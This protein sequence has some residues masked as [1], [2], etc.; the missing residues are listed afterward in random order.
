MRIKQ[1]IIPRETNDIQELLISYGLF[2]ILLDMNYEFPVTLK[3]KKGAYIIDLEEEVETEDIIVIPTEKDTDIEKLNFNQMINQRSFNT[4][5]AKLYGSPDEFGDFIGGFLTSDD[6]TIDKIFSYY[7][8]L[9]DEHIKSFK[10]EKSTFV[11]GVYTGLGVRG[12]NSPVPEQMKTF[13]T[14]LSI[15]GY[16]RATSFTALSDNGNEFT[17][18]AIPSEKGIEYLNKWHPYTKIDKETGEIVLS[19]FL[20]STSETITSATLKVKLQLEISMSENLEDFYGFYEIQVAPTASTKPL[21]DKVKEVTWLQFSENLLVE[22]NKLLNYSTTNIDV[23]NSVASF[24]TLLT[25][26]SYT[27]M[28]QIIAKKSS[29]P[30]F[31]LGEAKEIAKMVNKENLLELKAIKDYAYMLNQFMYKDKGIGYQVQRELLSVNNQSKLMSALTSM[32]VRYKRKY[33]FFGV[34][35][36]SVKELYDLTLNGNNQ[37]C[38]DVANAILLLSTVKTEEYLKAVAN[39]K[40]KKEDA[41][42]LKE[43]KK[44]AKLQK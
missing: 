20:G 22:F 3:R 32:N 2:S 26:K 27:N 8:T 14:R 43:E 5:V 30:L 29:Y 33:D 10:N 37:L 13:K 16:Y 36:T 4:H 42:K 21:N 41:L 40:K 25:P 11:N 28:I 23:K 7:A 31:L 19:Y 15:L 38:K 6:N 1:L 17:W 24:I 12:L 34:E 35:E 18:L 39:N 9:D 44:L